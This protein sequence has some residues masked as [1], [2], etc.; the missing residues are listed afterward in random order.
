[1]RIEEGKPLRS[2]FKNELK[3]DISGL[4]NP[5]LDRLDRHPDASEVAEVQYPLY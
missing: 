4:N 5:Q 1:V 2:E 3:E